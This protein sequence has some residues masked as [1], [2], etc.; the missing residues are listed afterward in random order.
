SELGPEPW[1]TVIVRDEDSGAERWRHK[2]MNPTTLSGEAVE[3]V[4]LGGHSCL[5]LVPRNHGTTLERLDHGKPIWTSPPLFAPP[6]VAAGISHD[7][8]AFYLAAEG[9]LRAHRLVD[10]REVWRQPLPGGQWRWRTR[11]EGDWLLAWPAERQSMAFP[12]PL[13]AGRLEWKL[14]W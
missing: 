8:E 14:F 6:L 3:R 5:L 13:T 11:R 2:L 12:V 7:D 1:G 9:Q 10:G 4:T